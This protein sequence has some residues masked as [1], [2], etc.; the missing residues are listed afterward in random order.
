MQTVVTI[1]YLFLAPHFV[2]FLSL[3]KDQHLWTVW[4]AGVGAYFHGFLLVTF[5]II[6]YFNRTREALWVALFFLVS[7]VAATYLVIRFVPQFMGLGYA[8]AT[9]LSF[10]VA[11]AVL[12]W[13]LENIEYLTFVEQPLSKPALPKK[14]PFGVTARE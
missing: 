7:N 8:I 6:L 9:F 2:R 11:L 1:L 5:I 4:A 13:D 14:R 3:N 12:W 10:L